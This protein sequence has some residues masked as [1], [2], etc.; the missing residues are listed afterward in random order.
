MQEAFLRGS[1]VKTQIRVQRDVRANSLDD[2]VADEGAS[3][4]ISCD[5][6]I[7]VKKKESKIC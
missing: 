6:S 7:K 3:D 5:W 2:P 1:P 4:G